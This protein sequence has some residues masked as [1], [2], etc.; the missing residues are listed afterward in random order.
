MACLPA[1]EEGESSGYGADKQDG[2]GYH[3]V[4]PLVE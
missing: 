3:G 2:I 4:N 1:A